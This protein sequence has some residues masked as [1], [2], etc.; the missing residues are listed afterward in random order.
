MHLPHVP[1][2]KIDSKSILKECIYMD[3]ENRFEDPLQKKLHLETLSTM[4][5]EI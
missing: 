5:N 3:E 2:H 4:E 1:S